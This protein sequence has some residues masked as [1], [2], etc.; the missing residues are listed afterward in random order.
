MV[1]MEDESATP[2][3]EHHSPL[4]QLHSSEKHMQVPTDMLTVEIL[5]TTYLVID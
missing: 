3:P 2:L 5:Y 4:T 1:V